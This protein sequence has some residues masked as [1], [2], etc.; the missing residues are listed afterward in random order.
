MLAYKLLESGCKDASYGKRWRGQG[1]RAEQ[2]EGC[3]TMAASAIFACKCE[4]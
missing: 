2:A 4:S 1:K 3:G